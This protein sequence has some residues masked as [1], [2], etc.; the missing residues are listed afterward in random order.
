M[1]S[2]SAEQCSRTVLALLSLLPGGLWLGFNSD[3]FGSRH[4]HY[5]ILRSRKGDFQ[6]PFWG[7]MMPTYP[8]IIHNH[9]KF[10]AREHYTSYRFPRHPLLQRLCGLGVHYFQKLRRMLRKHGLPIQCFGPR[11]GAGGPSFRVSGEV[12]EGPVQNGSGSI[13]RNPGSPADYT[14]WFCYSTR[15]R[16]GYAA[17]VVAT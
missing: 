13:F 3:G 16:D 1:I 7:G 6:T 11:C 12:A 17:A 10:W 2:E 9:P 15:I 8:Y 5:R 14:C 4:F